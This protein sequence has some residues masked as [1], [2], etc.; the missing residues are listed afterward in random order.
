MS[1]KQELVDWVFLESKELEDSTN[2]AK[3]II[4]HS[5]DLKRDIAS[6]AKHCSFVDGTLVVPDDV[7]DS[8]NTQLDSYIPDLFAMLRKI[9]AGKYTD[10]VKKHLKEL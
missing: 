9:D 3:A 6:Y 8:I 5:A 10:I 4:M 7:I 2:L 1:L